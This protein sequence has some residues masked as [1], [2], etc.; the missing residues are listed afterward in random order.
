MD[1]G[2]AGFASSLAWRLESAHESSGAVRSAWKSLRHRTAQLLVRRY[3]SRIGIGRLS[4]F[5]SVGDWNPF[6]VR[7]IASADC[8]FL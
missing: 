6:P 7:R 4:T 2:F 1:R 5:S 3:F 8:V